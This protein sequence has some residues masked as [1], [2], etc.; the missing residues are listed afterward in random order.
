ML[1]G[2]YLLS[3]KAIIDGLVEAEV[4]TCRV[5]DGSDIWQPHEENAFYAACQ[6]FVDEGLWN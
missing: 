5:T 2:V 1:N 4:L 6:Q 3:A